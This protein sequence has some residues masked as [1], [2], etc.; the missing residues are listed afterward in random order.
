MPE[1]Y[2]YRQKR[3]RE[4]TPE[5][6]QMKIERDKEYEAASEALATPFYQKKH[7]VGVTREEEDAYDQAYHALWDDYVAWAVANSVMEEITP[8]MQLDEATARLNALLEEVNTLWE[9][10]GSPPL[11]VV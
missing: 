3:A 5:Q 8:Q 6:L 4:L 10:L 1:P 11:E 9:G 2:R 7:S